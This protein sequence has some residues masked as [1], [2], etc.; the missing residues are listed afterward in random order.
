MNSFEND[1]KISTL[2]VSNIL[3]TK[4][5]QPL[6]L[7][8]DYTDMIHENLVTP[9]S[10]TG[11][12]EI[13]YYLQDI[14]I[15]SAPNQANKLDSAILPNIYELTDEVLKNYKYVRV[16][17]KLTLIVPGSYNGIGYYTLAYL[18]VNSVVYPV[19]DILNSPPCNR[20]SFS[21]HD[22]GTYE[23]TVPWTHP[24]NF[25]SSDMPLGVRR[26]LIDLYLP[27]VYLY[28]NVQYSSVANAAQQMKIGVYITPKFEVAGFSDSNKLTP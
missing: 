20:I 5:T 17:F 1:Q 11:L 19:Y 22:S 13:T 9:M 25:I 3:P 28:E 12:H 27:S 14:T 16:S 24:S 18:P 23:I 8:M 10:L 2:S 15:P 26:D 21:V 6:D 4:K 7:A